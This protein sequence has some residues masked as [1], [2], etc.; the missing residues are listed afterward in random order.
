MVEQ[1]SS[2]EF[3]KTLERM[4]LNKDKNHAKYPVLSRKLNSNK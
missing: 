3:E 2:C 4:F 1:I